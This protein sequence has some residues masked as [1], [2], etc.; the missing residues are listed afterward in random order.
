[1]SAT[2]FEATAYWKSRLS[3]QFDLTGVG[4]RRRSVGFNRWVYEARSKVLDS[5]FEKHH[6][7]I[8]GQAVLD[9]GC[10][11]GYFIEHWL[12]RQASPLA[13][14]DV[15]GVSVEKLSVRYPE[16]KFSCAD[17]AA[18]ELDMKE[19]FDY[20]SVFDVL[21]HIVDDGKFAQ[22][23]E[24]LSR[25][26]RPGTKVLVTDQFGSR[27][28]SMVKHCRHRSLELYKKVFS[29]HGFGL[30]G[31]KPL[32]YTMMPPTGLGNGLL[33]WVGVLSW[34]ATTWLAR[35]QIFGNLLGRLLYS[36]DSVLRK[37]FPRSPSG[38][39]AI[40]EFQGTPAA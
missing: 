26:C 37:V 22:A 2:E 24:N 17:I 23:V 31:I 29:S 27:T 10:G 9:V 1:M 18:E 30:F 14:V 28:T 13:G 4:H 8:R 7:P 32:F 12:R 40:F 39:M 33:R 19:T 34:E 5:T 38:Q 35:W 25:L 15:A 11:T 6:W 36:V 20:I 3:E 16:A 21:F